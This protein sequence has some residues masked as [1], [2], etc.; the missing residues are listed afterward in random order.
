MAGIIAGTIHTTIGVVR[1][2]G[3]GITG[4]TTLIIGVGAATRLI[5]TT[6]T[7]TTTTIITTR[8]IRTTIVR[9]TEGRHITTTDLHTQ[10]RA[11]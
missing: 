8:T 11:V 10:V 7:I 6:I 9:R 5:L 3:I 1:I 4:G 2:V